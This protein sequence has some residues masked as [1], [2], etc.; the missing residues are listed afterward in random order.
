MRFTVWVVAIAA[1]ASVVGSAS[2]QGFAMSGRTPVRN[3]GRIGLWNTPSYLSSPFRLTDFFNSFR[4]ALLPTP[5][6]T[7]QSTP[8]PNDPNYL[9]A[10]GYKKLS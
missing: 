7:N 10:F 2:A 1:A 3:G 4:G 6:R 8:N 5:T 9:K